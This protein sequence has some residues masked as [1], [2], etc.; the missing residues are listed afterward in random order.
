MCAKDPS[1]ATMRAKDATTCSVPRFLHASVMVPSNR[2]LHLG[3]RA[4]VG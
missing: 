1:N 4:F 3:I 2:A